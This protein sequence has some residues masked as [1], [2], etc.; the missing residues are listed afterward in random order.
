MT[1]A[2]VFAALAGLV[3]GSFLNVV[4]YRLPRGESPVSPGSRCPHC[5][6]PVRPRDNVPVLAWFL[7]RG[8]CRDCG[9]PISPRYAIVEATTGALFA[10]IVAARYPDGAAIGLGLVLVTFLVPLA[11]IDLA[12]RRL[13][14]RLVY[15]GA[16]LAL[17][18]GL[19][20]DPGGEPGRLLA[21]AI[22]GGAFLLIAFA[23][24]GGMGLGDVKLV[25]MLGL[26]LGRDV[27]VAIAAALLSGITLGIAIMSRKG[28]A[29][30]RKT[31]VPFGPFLALGGVLAILVGP[32]IMHAYL[33]GF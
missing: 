27:A 1:I 22:A 9:A 16:M 30:G 23:Y 14:D 8:R 11:L 6:H 2:V 20:L 7:L 28:M 32:D 29:E 19:W 25:G 13:P 17:V 18:V 26:F 21:G 12:E 5:E 4:A 31:A 10:V 33:R 24:P 15:P 3:L